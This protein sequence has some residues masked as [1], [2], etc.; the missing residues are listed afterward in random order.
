M[1]NQS[2][3]R[4]DAVKL[5]HTKFNLHLT[6]QEFTVVAVVVVLLAFFLI[7]RLPDNWLEAL[8]VAMRPSGS[9]TGGV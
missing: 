9:A 1:G 4:A 6:P 8:I 5:I 7:W 3:T 2:T